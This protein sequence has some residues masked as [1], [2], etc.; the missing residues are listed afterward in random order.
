M[1]TLSFDV[2]VAVIFLVMVSVL[3]AAH[4]WGHY[5]F[6]RLFR[7]GIEE[8]SIGIGKRLVVWRRRN[9]LVPVDDSYVHDP[10]ALSAGLAFEGGSLARTDSQVIESSDGRFLQETTEFT[11]RMLPVGGFVRIKGMVPED[12]GSEIHIPGGFYNKPPWQRLI[13]L[14]GGPLFS[15][16]AGLVVLTGVYAS[17]GIEKPDLR[18][19]I[20]LVVE[21]TKTVHQPAWDAG[22]RPGDEIVSVDKQPIQTFYQFVRLVNTHANVPMSVVYRRADKLLTTTLTPA[23]GESGVYDEALD[24][25]TESRVQ[26]RIGVENSAR[27]VSQSL[28]EAISDAVRMPELAVVGLFDIVKKPSRFKDDAGSAISM[29]RITADVMKEGA[30]KTIEWAGALSIM[31]GIFNLLP[32]PPLDGGQMVMAFAEMLRGGRRLSIRVQQALVNAGVVA[33]LLLFG[34]AVFFDVQRLTDNS[35]Q[36][37]T[38]SPPTK[39]KTR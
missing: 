12:D 34:F 7:M 3:V 1:G 32:F 27:H 31:L 30:A 11:V 9:Y 28:P 26:G 22:L 38:T 23:L 10:K 18:P 16:I 5:L 13:V 17:T 15:V 29:V 37:V 21:G 8:F 35:G 39:Q 36:A 20:G 24:P 14:I 4:E 2:S 6:A 19:I 33:V 25:P